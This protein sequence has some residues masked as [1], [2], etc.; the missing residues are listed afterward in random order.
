MYAVCMLDGTEGYVD[1]D[2][3]WV[4]VVHEE[5]DHAPESWGDLGS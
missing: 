1:D 5:L 4:P 2:G 3:E